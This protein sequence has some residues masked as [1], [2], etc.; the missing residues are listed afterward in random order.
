MWLRSVVVE[1]EFP[2]RHRPAMVNICVARYGSV[3]LNINIFFTRLHR[4]QL[5]EGGG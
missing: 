3:S 2:A 1:R 4:K 5:A